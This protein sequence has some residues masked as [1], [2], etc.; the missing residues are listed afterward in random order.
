MEVRH[1]EKERT[2][3]RTQVVTVDQADDRGC[4][5]NI[6]VEPGYG[7]A[8]TCPLVG[9]HCSSLRH[10]TP[11]PRSVTLSRPHS[12]K[13]PRTKNP[14]PKALPDGDRNHKG[15]GHCN[16]MPPIAYS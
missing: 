12:A 6:H 9:I 13:L 4:A 14:P 2:R 8:H 16:G 7:P 11:L 1:Q 10:D 3:D 15:S 5:G